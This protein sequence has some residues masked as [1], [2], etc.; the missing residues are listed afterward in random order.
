MRLL[1]QSIGL[2]VLSLGLRPGFPVHPQDA[3]HDVALYP[4]SAAFSVELPRLGGVSRDAACYSTIPFPPTLAG[5][6]RSAL[7]YETFHIDTLRLAASE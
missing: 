5:R 2:P 1:G 6:S 4:T 3:S 7:R